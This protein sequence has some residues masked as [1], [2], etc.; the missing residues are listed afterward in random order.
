MQI[1]IEKLAFGGA[2]IGRTE[3]K[4]V[5]VRGGLPGDVLKV[6]ITKEKGRYA[7]AEIEDM[8]TPSL[9]RTEPLCPVFGKCGGCQ[10]QHLDYFAQLKAK[11]G[12]LRETLERIGGLKG[13]EIEPI[14]PSPK[15]YG[16]RNRVTLSVWFQKGV[17]NVGYYEERSR[18]QI[19]IEGCPVASKPI[20]EA[21]FR[22]SK[23]LSSISSMNA[24]RY[25]VEK[26]HI[27][28]DEKIA[29]ITLVPGWDEDP[30]RL[31]S[32]RDQLK[33]SLETE[34]VYVA[35]DD[36][37]E[38]EFTLL[39]LKFYS[40][41]SL[42][43]QTNWEISKLLVETLL[44]WSDL[45]GHERVLDLY[46]GIGNFSL[47]LA[48]R[49]EEVVGVDVSAKAVNLAKKSAEANSISNAAFDA[50]PSELFIEESVKRGDGFDLVVLDPPRQGAK[51]ILRGLS[52]LSPKRIIYVSCDPP[53]LARDLKTLK[54]L[55][56]GTLKICPF[57][58]FPQTY[59]IESI[60]L[61]LKI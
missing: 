16:Y 34:I 19:E 58:M 25:P 11:E 51:E 18:R 1:Q 60:A 4:V 40:I 36:E 22:L 55:G 39:G 12:I 46:S 6:R 28:S 35:G 8:V 5:F 3:G 2:G 23:F 24:P 42:F 57:D 38:F 26:I 56:Y 52:E 29:Y 44:E 10:W 41:P 48:K 30:K 50:S 17:Y 27:G 61:L 49:C 9:E 53:T 13:I 33:K 21:I 45:R 32:L 31:N 15:Q 59:H 7:E 47:N 43:I 37:R 20:N 54:D 14:A